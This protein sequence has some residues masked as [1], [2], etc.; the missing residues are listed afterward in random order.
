ML[1]VVQKGRTRPLAAHA[2]V[3]SWGISLALKPASANMQWGHFVWPNSSQKR[4][5]I[6]LIL[7]RAWGI[8]S[9][10]KQ[11]GRSSTPSVSEKEP[12]LG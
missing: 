11:V 1:M 2:L 3:G 8:L 6:A 12:S 10:G 9:P 7:Q 5:S 4:E